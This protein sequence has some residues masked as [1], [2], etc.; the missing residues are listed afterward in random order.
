[1]DPPQQRR[2]WT[3]TFLQQDFQAVKAWWKTYPRATTMVYISEKGQADG[4]YTVD[5]HFSVVTIFSRFSR[6]AF[7]PRKYHDRDL[8][9]HYIL[10]IVYVYTIET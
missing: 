5:C 6:L 7:S 10:Y 2:S 8:E 9:R 4:M 1:M 3:K